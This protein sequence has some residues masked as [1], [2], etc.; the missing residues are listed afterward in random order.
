MSHHL[1]RQIEKLKNQ[2]TSLG[3]MV[4]QSLLRAMVSIERRDR[5]VAEQVIVDDDKI[6]EVEV[7]IEE[8]CLHTLALYQPVATDLRY[9]ISVLK[10]NNDLERIADMASNIAEQGKFLSE[11]PPVDPMP[12]DLTGMADRVRRM[13]ALALE[14]MLNSDPELAERVREAD[15]EVDD[16]HRQM[17]EQ[18]DSAMHQQPRRITSLIHYINI[19][20]QLERI[21]DLA[22]NIAED[23]IYSTRGTLVR[24]EH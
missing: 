9:V 5:A 2:I 19:S 17:Y 12:F 8:E 4:E 23:V 6:D 16:I 20:R 7:D 3:N 15:D 21:A 24:H 11:E 10:I 1:Q 14:A 18:V 13:L 22:T